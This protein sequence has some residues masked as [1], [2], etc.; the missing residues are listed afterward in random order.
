[1]K[2]IIFIALLLFSIIGCSRPKKDVVL[3][4]DPYPEEKPR[5]FVGDDN[6]KEITTFLSKKGSHLAEG[7]P[8]YTFSNYDA[9]YL[10]ILK[11]DSIDQQVEVTAVEKLHAVVF[12]DGHTTSKGRSFDF[13][14]SKKKVFLVPPVDS[15]D[16]E[17]YFTLARKGYNDFLAK[18]T[19][20]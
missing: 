16:T 13:V 11:Q 7:Y 17:N 9:Y 12:F 1:M 15:S 6:F 10:F 8:Y 18:A 19:K 5:L 14:I 3:I 2:K 20:K 4:K